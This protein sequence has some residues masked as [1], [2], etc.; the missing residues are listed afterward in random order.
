MIDWIKV[1]YP[2]ADIDTF[3]EKHKGEMFGI[4][5][6]RT[7]DIEYPYTFTFEEYKITIRY[8]SNKNLHYIEIA[9]SLHKNHFN[10]PN[11]E[12]FTYSA[13]TE[14]IQRLCCYF[15]TDP[16]NMRIQNLE[17]GVNLNTSFP[18][19]NIF[20][21]TCYCIRPSRLSHMVRGPM[22]KSWA[23]IVRAFL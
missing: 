6:M 2:H 12:R 14:E 13:L 22:G 8:S 1:V 17:V 18:H 20:M 19:T 11:F 15:E 3:I 21:I 23:T 9:G 5:N 10:G 4:A 16:G 7:G